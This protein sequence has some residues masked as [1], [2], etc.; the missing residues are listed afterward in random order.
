MTIRPSRIAATISFGL[1]LASQTVSADGLDQYVSSA[2]ANFI[3][4]HPGYKNMGMQIA[5][6]RA[7][8]TDQRIYSWGF[9]DTTNTT[10]VDAN[11]HFLVNSVTKT[12]TAMLAAVM[13]HKGMMP[14]GLAATLPTFVDYPQVDYRSGSRD[15]TLLDLA[16]HWSG[17]V[18]N[19]GPDVTDKASLYN[20]VY[21]NT[22]AL[23]GGPKYCYDPSIPAYCTAPDVALVYSNWGYSVLGDVLGDIYSHGTT[24][25][26]ENDPP[27]WTDALRAYVNAPLGLN[28]IT[29]TGGVPS[30]AATGYLNPADGPF[31]LNDNRVEDYDWPG[32][33]LWLSAHGA[34]TWMN[35]NLENWASVSGETSDIVGAVAT[36]IRY[37]WAPYGT[38]PQ[39]SAVQGLAWTFFRNNGVSATVGGTNNTVWFM[40]KIGNGSGYYSNYVLVPRHSPFGGDQVV[41]GTNIGGYGVAIHANFG[42]FGPTGSS[43]E[44]LESDMQQMTHDIATYIGGMP[45][46]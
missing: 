34:I 35:A 25:G 39:T 36:R 19:P 21:D 12:F 30:G 26:Y 15:I 23:F 8:G 9:T 27:T 37:G 3:S 24:I 1:L 7:D 45:M 43:T 22:G 42:D 17:L 46:H 10:F 40:Q 31:P 6:V 38:Y 18:P 32:S 5:L 13:E 41:N 33:G 14:N 29:S 20:D 44:R 16:T 4:L 2:R 11:T 28:V